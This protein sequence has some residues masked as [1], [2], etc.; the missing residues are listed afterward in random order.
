M[1]F[2][3]KFQRERQDCCPEVL[4][5]TAISVVTMQTEDQFTEFKSR[6]DRQGGYRIM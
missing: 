2:R 1:V 5:M 4:L 3:E 6:F